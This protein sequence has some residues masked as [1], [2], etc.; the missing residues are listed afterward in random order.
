MPSPKRSNAADPHRG[1]RRVRTDGS[2]RLVE[3]GGPGNVSPFFAVIW[4]E[5]TEAG[6]SRSRRWSTG[7]DDEALAREQFIRWKAARSRPPD[8]VTIERIVAGY[9]AA[10]ESKHKRKIV[11]K[12][13]APREAFGPLHPDDVTPE[14]T[15][16]YVRARLKAARQ[17][18]AGKAGGELVE[19]TGTVSRGTVASELAYLTAALNWARA[20]RW[21]ATVPILKSPGG[22]RSRK[23]RL[24]QP[25]AARLLA[26]IRDHETPSHVR[27]LVTLGLFTGQRS[28]HLRALR[29][30]DVDF[31]EGMI[32]FSRS[33][34]DAA[35]NKRVADVPM[36]ATLARFLT[37]LRAAARTEWVIEYRDKPVGSIKRAWASLLRRAK[38]TDFRFHDLRR[39]AASFALNA[40]VPLTAVAAFIADDEQTA[41]KHYAHA[42]PQLLSEVVDSIARTLDDASFA[43]PAAP[44]IE[45]IRAVMRKMRIRA[46]GR[47][48]LIAPKKPE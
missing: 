31:D 9:L 24:S 34:A 1:R 42:N 14:F 7:A 21:I 40:G 6:A 41:A 35:E 15:R 37:L 2:P 16:Q 30:A 43:V 36:S 26:A 32:W 48:P 18:S 45:P 47:L 46:S 8:A 29:W 25:E 3:P 17:R 44:E 11:S 10:I 19:R 33:N 5:R 39:S 28:G 27:A 4:T 13:R 12:L 23:R 20:E 38:L 22:A